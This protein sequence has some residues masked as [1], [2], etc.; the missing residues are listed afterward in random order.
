[1]QLNKTITNWIKENIHTV[2]REMQY[3]NSVGQSTY[4]YTN[5]DGLV[6]LMQVSEK[7]GL[8]I[9]P[10]FSDINL[11]ATFLNNQEC[12]KENTNNDI[13][14]P[15][16]H[17]EDLT[18]VPEDFLKGYHLPDGELCLSDLPSLTSSSSETFS[19]DIAL[20][21]A[22]ALATSV[23]SF[24]TSIVLQLDIQDVFQKL[25]DYNDYILKYS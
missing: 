2:F 23:N 12:L 18:I 1:M 15:S 14:I 19:K 13:D 7:L 22:G 4:V 6:C 16:L 11:F 24:L 10:Y 3:N 9:L 17:L 20:N 25:Q 5:I 21:K 8:D